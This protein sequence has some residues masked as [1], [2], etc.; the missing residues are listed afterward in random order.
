MA[1][2]L[3]C[4]EFVVEAYQLFRAR[5]AGADAV[6]LIA[7]VLPNKDLA[8]LSKAAR[9]VRPRG[10]RC[11]AAGAG[12]GPAWRPALAGH[13]WPCA[14]R[15]CKVVGLTDACAARSGCSA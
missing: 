11:C 5:V 15:V 12:P 8:Y 6:L 1:C 3:L 4:K 13:G 9:K 2:P 7:A 10:V 14:V